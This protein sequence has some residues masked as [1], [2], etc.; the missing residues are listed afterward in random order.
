MRQRPARF[1]FRPAAP[2][3]NRWAVTNVT[4]AAWQATLAPL[5]KII[6]GW[7]TTMVAYRRVIPLKQ[8]HPA[9]LGKAMARRASALRHK[10]T[11]CGP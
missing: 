5:T 3:R 6:S 9:Q 7:P 10:R 1:V 2:S 8:S 11:N 4:T